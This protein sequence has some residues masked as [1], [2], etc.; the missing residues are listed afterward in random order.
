[1]YVI[2]IK[3]RKKRKGKGK[4]KKK[5]KRK[6]KRKKRKGKGKKAGREK[7]GSSRFFFFSFFLRHFIFFQTRIDDFESYRGSPGRI[8][9]RILAKKHLEKIFRRFLAIFWKKCLNSFCQKSWNFAP[10]K[11]F[12]AFKKFFLETKISFYWKN[13][14]FAKYKI[15]NKKLWCKTKIL[16]TEQKLESAT[17]AMS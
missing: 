7:R 11:F 3:D 4:K 6:R 5:K 13:I 15:R 16:E 17:G 2:C 1:M 9:F 8:F 14:Y 10:K 12:I